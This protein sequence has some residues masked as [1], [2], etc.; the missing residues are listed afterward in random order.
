MDED[1]PAGESDGD[2]ISQGLLVRRANDPSFG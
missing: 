2:E 1:L